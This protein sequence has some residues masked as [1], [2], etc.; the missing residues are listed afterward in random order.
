[1]T[2]GLALTGYGCSK[3]EVMGIHSMTWG[4]SFVS[5]AMPTPCR[6]SLSSYPEQYSL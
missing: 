2:A 3:G 6:P 4:A 1:M 5:I